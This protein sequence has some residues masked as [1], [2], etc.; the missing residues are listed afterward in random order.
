M[1]RSETKMTNWL[2]ATDFVPGLVSVIVPNYNHGRYLGDAIDSILA[3][4]YQQHETIVIDDGSTDNSREVAA[5][6]G[7]QIRYIYKD[8][9]GLSAARNTGLENARGEFV[10]L[11]DADDMYEPNFMEKLV[12]TLGRNSD[13]DG[14]YCG[15]QFVDE[16]GE[17]LAQAETRVIPSGQLYEA[18]KGGNFWVPESAMMRR[19][20]YVT[21]GPYD[22]TLRACEDWDVWLR[23][24]A[25]H[26]ILGVADVL[27][28]HRVLPNSMS[29]DP[30]RMIDNRLAVVKTH[31]GTL[32]QPLPAASGK[33]SELYAQSYMFAAIEF[34]QFGDSEKAY[35]YFA[36]AAESAPDLLNKIGTFYELAFGAQPKG[37]RGEL[38]KL[39]LEANGKQLLAFLNRLFAESKRLNRID[40]GTVLSL[41]NYTLGMIAYNSGRNKLARQYL[42]QALKADKSPTMAKKI[43]KLYLKSII[44]SQSIQQLKKVVN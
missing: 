41:A 24:L 13:F 25:K 6:Y 33:V 2:S 9:A 1:S 32:D 27:T 28:R 4:T 31:F 23:I 38:E 40:Q 26:K 42:G 35:A 30:T 34:L 11:L 37:S 29:S 17:D 36:Q 10:A 43:S 15:Y 21:A 14:V 22:E 7:D 8:N 5:A 12:T 3:Q 39:D 20:C 44:G 16:H 19:K 18:M